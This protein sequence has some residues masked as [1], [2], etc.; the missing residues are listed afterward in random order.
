MHIDEGKKFDIRNIA[1]NIKG[2]VFSRK[3]YEAYLSR[4][5]DVSDKIFCPEAEE[6]ESSVQMEPKK[7]EE[8]KKTTGKRK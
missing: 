2:G 5:P 8:K 6:A 4:V 3:E 7:R 1:G